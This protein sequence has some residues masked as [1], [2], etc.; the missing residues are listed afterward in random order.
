MPSI[1]LHCCCAPCAIYPINWLREHQFEVTALW[2]NPNVHPFTEHQKRLESMHILARE[3]SLPLIVSD[4]YEMID[5]FRTVVGNEGNRCPDCYRLR[6]NKTAQIAHER[7]FDAFTTTLFISPYQDHELITE[8]GVESG[9]SNGIAFH[10]QDFREGFR[11]SH[12]LSRE[13]GL[14]HQKYCGCVYSEWERYGK[15]KIA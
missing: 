13:L 5:Y 9:R 4:G 14:Y 8:A 12:R 2:H 10:H 11:E 3:M 15:L 1:L 6:L 7:G